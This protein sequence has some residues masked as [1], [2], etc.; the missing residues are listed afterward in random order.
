MSLERTP[1]GESI[2]LGDVELRV[3]ELGIRDGSSQLI[4]PAL[5]LF[6]KPLEVRG[7][8]EGRARRGPTGLFRHTKPPFLGQGSNPFWPPGVRS[9]GRGIE[10]CFRICRAG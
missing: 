6:A 3:R 5:C 2:L 7:I 1:T 8:R 10:V 9:K 4:E